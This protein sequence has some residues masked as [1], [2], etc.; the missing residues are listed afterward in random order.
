MHSPAHGHSATAGPTVRV[1]L[2][3]LPNVV[4]LPNAVLPLH[5]FEPRYREMTRDA[6][7]GDKVIAMALLKPG[8]ESDYHGRP[9][10][11]PVVCVGRILSHEMLEDGR[12]NFLLQGMSRAR[13]IREIGDRPYRMADVDLMT[14]QQV[15]EIDLANER[16][17][18]IGM[19]SETALMELPAASQF[20]KLLMGSLP[21]SAVADVVAFS[22]IENPALKQSLLAETDPRRRITRLLATLESLVPMLER[23]LMTSRGGTSARGSA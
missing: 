21:T 19:F 3:P 9:P 6:L 16:Q 1:P 2:F 12:F 4:L 13:V 18:L 8:W 22:L 17:R 14:D 7:A 15:M 20:K 11:D 10:I 23:Q 5:I